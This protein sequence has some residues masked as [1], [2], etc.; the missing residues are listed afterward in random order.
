[1]RCTKATGSRELHF[2]AFQAYPNRVLEIL[3]AVFWRVPDVA[4]RAQP[5]GPFFFR[6]YFVAADASCALVSNSLAFWFVTPGGYVVLIGLRLHW[7]RSFAVF[8]VDPRG[9]F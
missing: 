1:M 6:Y 2:L 4:F 5:L 3:H 8:F 9:Y 7:V